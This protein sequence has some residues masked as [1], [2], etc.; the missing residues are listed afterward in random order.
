M[1]VAVNLVFS[2][3]IECYQHL[4]QTEPVKPRVPPVGNNSGLV[5]SSLEFK[6]RRVPYRDAVIAEG[7]VVA[8]AWGFSLHR[9]VATK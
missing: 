9:A 4:G 6:L 5:N 8:R 2:V 3:G 1:S 7:E